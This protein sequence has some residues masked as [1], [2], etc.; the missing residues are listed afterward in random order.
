[1]RAVGS[2]KRA[3]LDYSSHTCL[4]GMSAFQ[5]PGKSCMAAGRPH[6]HLHEHMAAIPCNQAR[7]GKR[8]DSDGMEKRRGK[9]LF[10]CSVHQLEG[11]V[12]GTLGEPISGTIVLHIHLSIVIANIATQR[13]SM[14][15]VPTSPFLS[16]MELACPCPCKS[17]CITAKRRQKP[18]W[19]QK[20]GLRFRMS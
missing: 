10:K 11:Q 1:M 9:L 13:Q 20:S 12:P 3:I 4:R 14:V 8:P 18:K 19:P 6:K 15:I 5:L 17:S 7:P 16:K 2:A